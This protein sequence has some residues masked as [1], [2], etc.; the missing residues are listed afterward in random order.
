MK[1]SSDRYR[2]PRRRV[3]VGGVEALSA[4]QNG[5]LSTASFLV[6]AGQRPEWRRE[7]QAE[8]WHV[9]HSLCPAGA[10]S[11]PAQREITFFCLGSLQD[12]FCLRRESRRHQQPMP[13]ISGAAG[14]CL[15]SLCT[16]LGVAIVIACLL[17]GVQAERDPSRFQVSPGLIL[18]QVSPSPD[19]SAPSISAGLFRNWEGTHQRYFDDFAF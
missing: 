19:E 8:L 3:F 15:L 12:A 4:V 6:P 18:I 1:P 7:W 17:P 5:V 13:R 10:L 14:Q 16:L 2:G 11:W 9:R